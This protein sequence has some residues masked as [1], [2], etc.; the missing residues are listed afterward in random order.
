[1]IGF[2]KCLEPLNFEK[3]HPEIKC[4]YIILFY[5]QISLIEKA[6]SF[7]ARKQLKH[8]QSE[9]NRTHL[10]NA[11]IDQYLRTMIELI[12]ETVYRVVSRAMFAQHQI[13]FSFYLCVR[14]HMHRSTVGKHLVEGIDW[15]CFLYGS[16]TKLFS[17]WDEKEL[18]PR[19]GTSLSL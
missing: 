19:R 3:L 6:R 7:A 15:Q 10:M 16:K 12:T 13:L 17:T 1:M 2:Q 14:I 8:R 5:F 4:H 9:T 18:S 11:G